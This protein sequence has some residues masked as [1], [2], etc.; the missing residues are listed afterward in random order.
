MGI[1]TT[2]GIRSRDTSG[3]SLQD[4]L[5]TLTLFLYKNNRGT[6]QPTDTLAL[7]TIADFFGYAS[8]FN[9]GFGSPVLDANNNDQYTAADVVF[10]MTGAA[11]TNSI[12]GHGWKD[13]ANDLVMVEEAAGVGGMNASGDTYTVSPNYYSGQILPP[14]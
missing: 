13:L 2:A 3:L 12:Y 4:W 1:M 9:V 8:V 7:Y 14:V 5:N 11:P 10:T 6:P